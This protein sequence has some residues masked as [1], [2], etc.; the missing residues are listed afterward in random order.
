[1]TWVYKKVRNHDENQDREEWDVGYWA[2]AMNNNCWVPCY[3]CTTLS[4]AWRLV[5]YLSKAKQEAA[6]LGT[7]LQALFLRG[8]KLALAEAKEAA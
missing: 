4:G 3:S 8:L 1:M 6:R 2:P 5:S 7:T